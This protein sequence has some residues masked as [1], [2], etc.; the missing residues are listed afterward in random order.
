M[1]PIGLPW[2]SSHKFFKHWTKTYVKSDLGNSVCASH[3]LSE[4]KQNLVEI[5]DRKSQFVGVY[6]GLPLL[7]QDLTT[8]SIVQK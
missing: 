6:V 2:D 5:W 1:L 4:I 3:E 7:S 8:Y